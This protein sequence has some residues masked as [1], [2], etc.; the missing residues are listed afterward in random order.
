MIQSEIMS[1]L[2]WV[3]CKGKHIN[4]F[5]LRYEYWEFVCLS[6]FFHWLSNDTI[7][8]IQNYGL[9]EHFQPYS[10]IWKLFNL[11]VLF[12]LRFLTRNSYIIR[13][14]LLTCRSRIEVQY[15]IIE[16]KLF[17]HHEMA[18]FQLAIKNGLYQLKNVINF[19]IESLKILKTYNDTIKDHKWAHLSLL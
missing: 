6:L 3:L 13:E 9:E 2:I 16:I 11:H 19:K 15:T 10:A 18:N 12:S 17:F 5:I 4:L 7:Q 14:R 1:G 8:H